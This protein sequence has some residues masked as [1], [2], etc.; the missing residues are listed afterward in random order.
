MSS[1]PS[2]ARDSDA[3]A[4][5]GVPKFFYTVEIVHLK[6][7]RDLVLPAV[8]TLSA[9][10]NQKSFAALGQALEICTVIPE[11]ADP[12]CDK[13]AKSKKSKLLQDIKTVFQNPA[14]VQAIPNPTVDLF[15][16]MLDSNLFRSI[17]PTPPKY[18]F[19]DYEP[20]VVD[21]A[22]AHL[23][24]V[25]DLLSLFFAAKPKDPHF[26][27]V[28]ER[29]L[30]KLFNAPDPNERTLLSDFFG[31]YCEQYPDREK[32]L[33][34][35]MGYM[36]KRYRQKDTDPYLVSP[37]LQVFANR[38][39]DPKCD[40]EFR[41]ILIKEAVTPLISSQHLL[42]FTDKI[43]E[44]ILALKSQG[45]LIS[46]IKEVIA[47]WPQGCPGKQVEYISVINSL[48][49]NL[50]EKE[51]PHVLQ[52]MFGLYAKLGVSQ[53]AK[54]AEA[55]YKIWS[56]VKLLP[57]ILDHTKTVFLILHPAILKAMNEH[58]RPLTQT[59]ALSA[60]KAM[61][62]LDPVVFDQLKLSPAKG[63][64]KK[65][66]PPV[67]DEVLGAKSRNW[68]TIARLAARADRSLAL[69]QLLAAITALFGNPT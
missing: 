34:A 31:K 36:L 57:R 6:A 42:S 5:D 4:D 17:P 30:L 23:S 61:Q 14:F 9:D 53:F 21:I 3:G 16:A 10:T 43:R 20:Y 48:A 52:L 24:L 15:F 45:A 32:N 27:L 1:G 25:Y 38:F 64:V 40:K 35:A 69:P 28:F 59:Q 39:K 47:R 51:F 62:E 49:E 29:N 26:T 22:W 46:F 55:S 11:W 66:A 50:G 18:L 19:G 33:W 60:L 56:N 7:H 12:D 2:S 13:E 67:V 44:V 58:W 63:K 8:P 68:G 65:G 37:V 41:T 54:A